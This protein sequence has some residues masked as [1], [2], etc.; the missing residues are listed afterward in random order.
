MLITWTYLFLFTDTKLYP[1]H[2]K[3]LCCCEFWTNYFPPK[4]SLKIYMSSVLFS[5]YLSFWLRP[6]FDQ[7]ESIACYYTICLN[8]LVSIIF[9][10]YFYISFTKWS[11]MQQENLKSVSW[12]LNIYL[13]YFHFN[14]SCLNQ[15]I[16]NFVP[17]YS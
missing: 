3:L 10:W 15:Y 12:V 11:D 4:S 2:S 17:T 14:Y 1:I 13:S 16:V 9:I 5:N 6:I 8:T 7:F